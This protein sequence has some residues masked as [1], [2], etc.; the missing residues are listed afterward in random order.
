MDVWK[1]HKMQNGSLACLRLT[2]S[3]RKG[4]RPDFPQPDC[5]RITWEPSLRNQIPRPSDSQPPS[6]R[7]HS[8]CPIP[9]SGSLLPLNDLKRTHFSPLLIKE[10][11]LLDNENQWSTLF[12]VM[13]HCHDCGNGFTGINLCQV[14][15]LNYTQFAVCWLYSQKAVF[16]SN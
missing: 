10:L 14:M 6:I 2:T 15:Y 11:G 1:E 9:S 5:I 16:N 8:L 4:S 7:L 13:V 3:P 12:K